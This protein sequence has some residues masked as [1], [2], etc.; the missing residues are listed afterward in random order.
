M[1]C[2][3]T[4]TRFGPYQVN[5]IT[6][7]SM[8]EAVV[9]SWLLAICPASRASFMRRGVGASVLSPL[10]SAMEAGHP[11]GEVFGHQFQVRLQRGAKGVGGNTESGDQY[12]DA[13]QAADRQAGAH[14]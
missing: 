14:D 7:A 12:R 5:S 4:S 9:R 1:I 6:A 3:Q 13:Q 2:R 11:V 10:S 8:S